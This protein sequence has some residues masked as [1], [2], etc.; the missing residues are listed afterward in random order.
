MKLGTCLRFASV[1][2]V[3]LTLSAL[4]VSAADKPADTTK[5]APSPQHQTVCPVMGGKIDSTEYTDIQGQRVYHCCG[6]CQKKLVAS[7]E[8]YFKKAA[9]QGVIFENIQKR[10][11]VNGQVLSAKDISTDYEGRRIY[12]SDKDCPAKFAQNP[13]KYLKILD[14][15]TK[16]DSSGKPAKKTEHEGHMHGM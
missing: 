1:A 14:Q 11:P 15:Q 9:A 13:V 6:G 5:P 16:E 10:C 12:F 8:K 4:A 3:A 2:A 7:P